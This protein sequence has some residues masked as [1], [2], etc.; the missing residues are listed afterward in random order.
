[1]TELAVPAIFTAAGSS[2]RIHY[3]NAVH[4]V[5]YGKVHLSGS[6]LYYVPR[7]SHSVIEVRLSKLFARVRTERYHKF[8]G[9]NDCSES[10]RCRC[11]RGNCSLSEGRYS[12][13]V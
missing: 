13:H 6:R 8:C 5:L 12:A 9:R 4:A 2:A 1:M 11:D 3:S 7:E 10:E